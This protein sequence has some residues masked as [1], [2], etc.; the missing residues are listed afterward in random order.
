MDFEIV[1]TVVFSSSK[2]TFRVCSEG[3]SSAFVTPGI[4]SAAET[5]AAPL[6][7]QVMPGTLNLILFCAANTSLIE[8]SKITAEMQTESIFKL[9]IYPPNNYHI[10]RTL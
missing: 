10:C 3:S 8:K 9:F 7:A 2:M 6:D 1:S 5:A 4:D